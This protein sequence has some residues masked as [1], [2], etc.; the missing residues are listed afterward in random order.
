MVSG[1]IIS[2]S[3]RRGRE[4]VAVVAVVVLVVVVSSSGS[5]G[6]SGSGTDVCG[7]QLGISQKFLQKG[8]CKNL[9][10]KKF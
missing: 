4:R 1:V 5:S 10:Q 9:L 8:F 6:S 3:S 7:L 2:S